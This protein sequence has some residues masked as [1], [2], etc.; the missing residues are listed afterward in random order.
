MNVIIPPRL[1]QIL[2]KKPIIIHYAIASM[3]VPLVGAIGKLYC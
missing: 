1:M 3:A 2:R